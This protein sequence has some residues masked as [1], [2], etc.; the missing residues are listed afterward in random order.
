L[1]TVRIGIYNIGKAAAMAIVDLIEG[2]VPHQ[3]APAPELIVREST[4]RIRH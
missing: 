1:T 4:K 2:R 3:A